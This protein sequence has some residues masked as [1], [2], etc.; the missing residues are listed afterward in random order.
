MKSTFISVI[1]HELKTPVALIK[2]YA[3]T[4]RRED[5]HWDAETLREGLQVIEE[6]SDRLNTLIN[7]LLD[8]SRIQAGG[9]KLERGDVCLPNAGGQGGR[10]LP[11]ADRPAITS[12][13]TSRPI[14]PCV[15]GDE[16]RLR[17]V[18]NNLVSNAIK[19]SPRGRRDPHRRLARWRSGS[20]ST[21]PTRA[22]ASRRGAGQAVPAL[23]PGRFQPAPQHAGRRAGPVPV[24]GHRRGARRPHLA[25]QRAGQ[26]H[27]R[28]LHAAGAGKR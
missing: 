11:P 8:A 16:E 2:G 4:L 27:D 15:S 13:S 7:N 14:C 24:Q 26:G 17:Q 9:F 22:S 23:L 1:S 25:A 12:S 20:R 6:E 19:Y 5:A 3:G 21:W 18:L 10:E 28:V